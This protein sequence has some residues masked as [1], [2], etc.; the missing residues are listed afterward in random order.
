[1]LYCAL[2]IIDFLDFLLQ[3]PPQQLCQCLRLTYDIKH[4]IDGCPTSIIFA[5]IAGALKN[6]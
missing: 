1:M 5:S 2:I 3:Y 4:Q 6:G